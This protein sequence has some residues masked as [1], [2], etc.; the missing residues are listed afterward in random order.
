MFTTNLSKQFQKQSVVRVSKT[1]LT[2]R[3]VKEIGA[4]SSHFQL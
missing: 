4:P 1:Y 3:R 2:H